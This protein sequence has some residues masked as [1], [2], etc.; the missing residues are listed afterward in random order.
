MS[1]TKDE[2]IFSTEVENIIDTEVK[3][4][5][6][7]KESGEEITVLKKKKVDKPIKVLF[8]KP[9]RRDIEEAEEAYSIEMSKSIM[10]GILTK[11]MLA[12]KYRESGGILTEAEETEQASF[13]EKLI[14]AQSDLIE[15]ESFA[16]AKESKAKKADREKTRLSLLASIKEMR[17]SLTDIE[18]PFQELFANTAETRA[19]NVATKWFFVNC[20]YS[21]E[22]GG[23]AVPVFSSPSFEDKCDEL[24]DLMESDNPI[25][26][27]IPELMTATS[28]WYFSRDN[29]IAKVIK[30]LDDEG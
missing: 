17:S 7:D 12:K 9:S 24:Y 5:Q 25:V 21:Q 18:R 3:E 28:V 6:K 8:K 14:K 23:E 30:E 1:N 11:P 4:V 27:A 16:P 19:Q 22:V 15:I 13:Y 10:K 20:S 29:D 26:S 2:F